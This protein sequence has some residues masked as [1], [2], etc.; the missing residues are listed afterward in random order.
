MKKSSRPSMA[1][2]N[3]QRRNAKKDAGRE[4]K[5]SNPL[6]KVKADKRPSHAK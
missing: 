3:K 5:N 4:G 6:T 2:V 1:I